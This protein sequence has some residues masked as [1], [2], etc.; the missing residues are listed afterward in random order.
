MY[1]SCYLVELGNSSQHLGIKRLAL[2][3]Q[4]A[5]SKLINKVTNSYVRQ[6]WHL[7]VADVSNLVSLDSVSNSLPWDVVSAWLRCNLG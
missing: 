2:R 6:I 5:L 1:Y 3:G 4:V 7:D